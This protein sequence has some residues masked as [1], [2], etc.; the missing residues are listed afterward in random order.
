MANRS[1]WL[2]FQQAVPLISIKTTLILVFALDLIPWI[3]LFFVSV[4]APFEH[5]GAFPMNDNHD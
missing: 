3:Y 5:V 4:S 1:L 2:S